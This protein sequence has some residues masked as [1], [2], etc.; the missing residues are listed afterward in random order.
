MPDVRTVID[1]LGSI[2]FR[3][4]VASFDGQ[5]VS[6]CQGAYQIADTAT[7]GLFLMMPERD[8]VITDI[9]IM[10]DQTLADTDTDIVISYD[11]AV[12]FGS[13]VVILNVEGFNATGLTA[14]IYSVPDVTGNATGL[15][16]LSPPYLLPANNILRA[17]FINNENAQPV[18]FAVVVDYHPADDL[19]ALTPD[20]PQPRKV[21]S[22]RARV[23]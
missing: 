3:E 15:V 4:L 19:L 21:Q 18:D 1:D 8:V 12:A 23:A 16:Q 2:A 14:G 9:R 17:V 6:T 7:A 22:V 5:V 10:V 20:A 11:D 13:P